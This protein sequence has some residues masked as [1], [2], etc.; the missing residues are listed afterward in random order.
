MNRC[1]LAQLDVVW[2]ETFFTLKSQNIPDRQQLFVEGGWQKELSFTSARI[3]HRSCNDSNYPT[4]PNQD[5]WSNHKWDGWGKGWIS[6]TS[7]DLSAK[8]GGF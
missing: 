8:G 4:A 2:Q 3:I 7:L 5:S 1:G 6:L